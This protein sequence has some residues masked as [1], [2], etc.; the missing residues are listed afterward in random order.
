LESFLS[1]TLCRVVELFH[2]DEFDMLPSLAQRFMQE[3]G[4]VRIVLDQEDSSRS[5]THFKFLFG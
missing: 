4:V 3:A 1:K 2:M 5:V